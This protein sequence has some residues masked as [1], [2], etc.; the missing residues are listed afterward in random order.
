MVSESGIVA[1]TV[2]VF[3][4]EWFAHDCIWI[5][6]TVVL[7]SFVPPFASTS[8]NVAAAS[9]LHSPRTYV[10]FLH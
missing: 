4:W 6:I 2:V 7:I 8:C 9:F 3:S 5:L 1:A 10:E